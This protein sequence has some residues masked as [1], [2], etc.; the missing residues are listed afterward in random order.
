[1]VLFPNALAVG[2]AAGLIASPL[3]G[4]QTPEIQLTAADG[5]SSLGGGTALI[6]GGSGLPTPSQTYADF[7]VADYLAPR[8]FTG[9]TQIVTTPEGLYPFLGPFGLVFDKSEAQ[10]AQLLATAIGDQIAGGQVDAANPVVVFGYSQGADVETVAMSLLAEQGVPRDLVHFVLVGDPANP[11]GGML[12]RFNLPDDSMP[13]I[14][15]LGLTFSGAT[16]D[17]LYPTDI[18]THEYDGF[19]DFPR[20]PINFLADLNAALGI[21]FEHTT[22]LG[23][24]PEEIADA[25]ALP[26]SAADTLTNY[27]MLPVDTLP[28]LAPLQLLPFIGDPLVDLLQPALRVLV[29][30]G[31]GNLEHGW[32]QGF[33][34]LPTPLGF[35]PDASV[36]QQV[37][38]ALAEGLVKGVTDALKDLADPNNYVYSLPSWAEQLVKSAEMLPGSQFS[39]LSMV[40]TTSEDLFGTFPPHTGIPPLDM[41]SAVL[42][43]LPQLDYQIFTSELADGNLLD[44]IGTPIAADLGLLPLI[45]VGALF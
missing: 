30:L 13:T 27:Y 42:F 28:L 5:R 44:A 35:L 29:N 15:S 45:V 7:A 20:Y 6:L 37:P 22:Y 16:P 8:G 32:D 11:N 4:A 19:A 25:V 18:Y 14:P 12:E 41:L 10:G 23:L 43:T 9:T 24:T 2:L 40:P 3:P 17:D 39:V 36:L 31:Y 34:D 33:A 1:M 26:T 21:I 38:Q